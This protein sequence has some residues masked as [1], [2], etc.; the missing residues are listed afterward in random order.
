M[1][2]RDAL[3]AAVDP[4]PGDALYFVS[5]NDGSH[6]FSATYAEHNAAVDCYQ[7]RR[8]C[9]PGMQAPAPRRG[10]AQAPR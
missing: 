9:P 8:N 10:E 4:A 1:P 3:R 6:V 7:R 2:G 5:R